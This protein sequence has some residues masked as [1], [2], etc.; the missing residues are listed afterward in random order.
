[1]TQKPRGRQRD[2]A[3]SE[4]RREEILD[5]AALAF[6][7]HGFAD[8][9]M[10]SIADAAGVSKGALYHY[11]AGKEALFLAAADR[12]MQRLN[13]AIDA[14][15]DLVPDQLGRFAASVEAYLAFFRDHPEFVE[16]L[17]Q[18]RAAFPDREQPTYFVHCE[19]NKERCAR[20]LQALIDAGRLRPQPVG[21]ILDAMSDLVYGTMFTN[22]F[23][24]RR[25]PVAEQARDLID[26][27]FRGILSDRERRKTVPGSY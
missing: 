14:A 5:A 12:G 9:E 22:H 17:I 26:F 21:R 19:A 3:L 13:A 23:N 11:F 18:E 7:K 15:A 20:D 10:Q 25:R 2:E 1:M 4:R 24:R 27:A 8:T 6:A 16:L